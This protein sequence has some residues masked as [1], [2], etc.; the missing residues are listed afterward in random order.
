LQPKHQRRYAPGA[1]DALLA[2][3][4]TDIPGDVPCFVPVTVSYTVAGDPI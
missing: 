2:T 1:E 3:I 4:S